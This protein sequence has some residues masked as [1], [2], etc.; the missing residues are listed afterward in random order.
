MGFCYS[1]GIELAQCPKG[2]E[3]QITTI[4][5]GGNGTQVSRVPV[6]TEPRT[7]RL[8]T[9][10]TIK[11]TQISQEEEIFGRGGTL[12]GN[13]FRSPLPS[14]NTQSTQSTQ[15]MPSSDPNLDAFGPDATGFSEEDQ[16]FGTGGTL[17]GGVPSKPLD[18]TDFNTD[19]LP[20][21][22]KLE[23]QSALATNT[24]TNTTASSPPTPPSTRPY[25]WKYQ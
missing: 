21:T 20:S 11:D 1:F 19:T 15:S 22:P 3:T 12:G 5:T 6:Y 4:S 7:G 24:N 17:G 14:Q 8:L 9:P 16:I 25:I 13:S 2:S 10:I 18:Q 23:G